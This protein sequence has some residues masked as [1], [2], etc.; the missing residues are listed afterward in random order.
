MILNKAVYGSVTGLDLII[1]AAILV[2]G[3]AAV[4]TISIYLRRFLREKIAKEHLEI[5]AKLVNYTIIAI[6]IIIVLAIVGVRLSGLLVAG[7]IAGLAIGF[8]S[9]S[10]VA[11]LISGIFLIIERRAGWA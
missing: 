4:K 11:N 7:G 5:I 6:A 1:A 8:A 3:V 10:I 9:Q 2:V